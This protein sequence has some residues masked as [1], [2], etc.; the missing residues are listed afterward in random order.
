GSSSNSANLL[1]TVQTTYSGIPA[2]W[3]TMLGDGPMLNLVPTSNTTILPN[4][5][6]S[7][8]SNTYDSGT[9]WT[10]Y[11]PEWMTYT[12]YP[13]IYGKL[14]QQDEYD[15]GSGAPGS[16]LRSTVT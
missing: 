15:Y 3:M 8:G 4:G 9:T 7:K 12:T 5:L 13:A 1:K 6:T 10:Y 2:P 11:D 14:L 16:L